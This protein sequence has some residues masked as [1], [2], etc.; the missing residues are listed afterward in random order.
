MRVFSAVGFVISVCGL[1]LACYNQFGLMPFLRDLHSASTKS[2]E[3][4]IHLASKYEDQQHFISILC[5]I[6]G[7]VSVL[8]CS[9]LYFRKKTRMTLVGSFL[10]LV[11]TILGIIQSL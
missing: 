10:G 9:T 6:I 11:V 3:L 8:L 7:V 1:L 2:Y 5:I 4:T